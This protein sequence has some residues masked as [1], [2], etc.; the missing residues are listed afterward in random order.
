[1]E[2]PDYWEGFDE[3]LQLALIEV[4][5]ILAGCYNDSRIK[6]NL[7]DL[8]NNINTIKDM[9]GCEVRTTLSAPVSK[10]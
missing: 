2:T 3:S 7:L 10:P 9:S 8:R 5:K 6:D 4:D 1:M